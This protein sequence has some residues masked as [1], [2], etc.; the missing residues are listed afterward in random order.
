MHDLEEGDLFS[1]ESSPEVDRSFSLPMPEN[2]S[3]QKQEDQHPPETGDK[4]MCSLS[5]SF[6][7]LVAQYDIS[8]S[9]AAAMWQ[10]GLQNR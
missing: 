3:P 1:Q 8:H 6:S 4:A 10:F 2:V 5:L 7:A 9:A